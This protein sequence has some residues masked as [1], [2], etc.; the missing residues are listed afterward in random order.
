[1]KELGTVFGHTTYSSRMRQLGRIAVEM[2]KRHEVVSVLVEPEK[3]YL[4]SLR[5]DNTII[6]AYV[7]W[8][9][10]TSS[11]TINRSPIVVIQVM[12]HSEEEY[13]KL[14]YEM[15]AFES[16]S[17]ETFPFPEGI[18]A[19]TGNKAELAFIEEKIEDFIIK[20]CGKK[21]V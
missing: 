15:D 5:N 9:Y 6:C 14:D 17:S 16:V 20:Y 18:N 21:S 1:M 7:S 19:F 12:R 4:K 13:L 2:S 11:K 3:L 10:Q 8:P